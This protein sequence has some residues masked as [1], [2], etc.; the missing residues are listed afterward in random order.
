MPDGQCALVH[1][2]GIKRGGIP[3]INIEEVE[4]VSW[5]VMVVGHHL[6]CK[7]D[8]PSAKTVCFVTLITV[9]VNGFYTF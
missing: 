3:F 2:G 6:Q 1:N 8:F 7:T 9:F 5:P 4:E